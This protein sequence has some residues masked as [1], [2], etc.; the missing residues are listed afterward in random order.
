MASINAAAA[1][2]VGADGGAG[3]GG[4]NGVR[5]GAI[6]LQCL[7]AGVHGG[8]AGSDRSGQ[9]RCHGN[10]DDRA[11]Q[12]RYGRAVHAARSD[13][14]PDGDSVAGSDAIWELVEQAAAVLNPAFDQL[15]WQAAQGEVPHNDDTG[16]RILGLAREPSDKR[17]GIFTSGIVSLRQN[18]KI[19]L[20]STGRATC[21]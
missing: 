6:A 1:E 19:A 17:T 15:I 4:S 9:V 18:R 11:T 8:R 7:R 12:V 5:D 20:F 3:A 16:L 2:N 14:K 13:G 21:G 10:C